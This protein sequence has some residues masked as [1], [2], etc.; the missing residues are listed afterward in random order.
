MIAADLGGR[1]PSQSKKCASSY[2]VVI[3]DVGGGVASNVRRRR[4]GRLEIA[5]VKCM[6]DVCGTVANPA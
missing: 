1:N 2:T 6:T 3:D 4:T 5:A